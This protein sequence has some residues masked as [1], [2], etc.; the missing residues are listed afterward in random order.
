MWSGRRLP[1]FHP[2]C[3]P[4]AEE[5]FTF[6]QALAPGGRAAGATGRN[7]RM[8]RRPRGARPC[9]RGGGERRREA[10]YWRARCPARLGQAGIPGTRGRAPRLPPAP[11]PGAPPP[12]PGWRGLARAGE[13]SGRKLCRQ[14]APA[15]KGISIT[16]SG[17]EPARP[18]GGSAERRELAGAAL[19]PA[20]A[21]PRPWARGPGRGRARASAPPRGL[22]RSGPPASPGRN[23]GCGCERMVRV[24]VSGGPSGGA[25]VCAEACMCP[26]VV[27]RGHLQTQ[28]DPPRS[29]PCPPDKASLFIP[30]PKCGKAAPV[31]KSGRPA[32]PPGQLSPSTMRQPHP[33][34]RVRGRPPRGAGP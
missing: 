7:Q 14:L 2:H 3:S 18:G 28:G 24:W 11:A 22:Q 34:S 9:E 10:A 12:L 23:S 4:A 19:P 15:G 20:A 1:R 31:L 32:E 5:P 30:A 27:C 29:F 21:R 33:G 25:R 6:H 13:G 16:K 26:S 8:P 17:S